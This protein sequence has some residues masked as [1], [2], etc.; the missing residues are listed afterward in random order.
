LTSKDLDEIQRR[1]P[2]KNYFNVIEAELAALE[3]E[4]ARRE[5]EYTKKESGRKGKRSS[6]GSKRRLR[7]M[8]LI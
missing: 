1:D 3:A 4:E 6:N 8:K 2:R 5:E 7:H